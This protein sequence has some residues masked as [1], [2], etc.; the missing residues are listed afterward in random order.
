MPRIYPP[1]SPSNFEEM[2]WCLGYDHILAIDEVGR[3]AV[4]GPITAAGV[5]CTKRLLD[6]P[7]LDRVRDSKKL[8]ARVREMVADEVKAA[9][10]PYFIAD[11]SWREIDERGIEA[12][13]RLAVNDVIC[14][15]REAGGCDFI[16]MDGPRCPACYRYGREV[17]WLAAIHGD[18]LHVS[19]SLAS[20]IAKA[21]RDA[22]M[23]GHHK[24]WP[25]YNFE[26]NKG[27]LTDR[28]AQALAEYGMSPLHRRSWGAVTAIARKRIRDDAIC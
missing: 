13:W 28:H 20:I 22:Q 19:I 2:L 8:S 12:A 1:R 7:W 27:Y 18:D 21:S 11:V 9:R 15:C 25:Q 16:L 23:R 14:Q 24:N 4:A 10:I 3:G 17:P 6:Y 26:S 5:V